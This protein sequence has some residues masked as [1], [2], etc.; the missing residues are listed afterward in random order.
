MAKSN[1]STETTSM[2]RS[3]W[4]LL[5]RT[6]GLVVVSAEK[7]DAITTELGTQTPVD[8]V[9]RKSNVLHSPEV[10]SE[11]MAELVASICHVPGELKFV[12][13]FFFSQVQGQMDVLFG[14][15]VLVAPLPSKPPA[16]DYGLGANV[17][18]RMGTRVRDTLRNQAKQ[19]HQ[20]LQKFLMSIIARAVPE[21]DQHRL[22]QE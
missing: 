9:L 4:E 21:V 3:L 17:I 1:V 6:P 8:V 18:L 13:H 2:E 15:R 5:E 22:N 10:Y 16:G 19:H 14:V 7:F 20:S 12:S 11:L